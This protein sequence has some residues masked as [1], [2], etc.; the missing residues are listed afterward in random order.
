M[1][2]L[3]I[4]LIDVGW[5][6]SIFLESQDDNG[7]YH[8]GLIDSNDSTYLRSSYI[9]LKKYFDKKEMRFPEDKP[10]FDFILLSHAHSDHSQGLKSIF[11]TFSTKH[12]W[13][14]KSNNWASTAD[15]IRYG[16]RYDYV[17][18]HQSIDDTKILPAF[19]DVSMEVLWPPYNQID[20]N[21]NNNSVVL[22][23][24]VNALSVILTGDAEEEVWSQIANKIP[25]DTVF[26]KVPHHGSVNGTFDNANNTPWF[27][28]CPDDALLGISSHIRPYGHP[29]QEV[30]NLL[31]LNNRKFYRTDKH[32][33]ITFISDGT[34]VK[35]KYSH[36]EYP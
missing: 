13:Y 34:G 9:F 33:H 14:S 25:Q 28:K 5:G 27:D 29:H 20:S 4:P 23:L 3:E 30:V 16:D 12:F 10:A 1:S 35:L 15:L 19:G 31:T 6:D 24:R 22:L 18:H 32:Y 26:F 11:K 7:N 36:P 8:Y 2:S 17:D 21:E